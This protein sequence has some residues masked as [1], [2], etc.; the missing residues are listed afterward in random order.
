[1]VGPVIC[2]DV[3]DDWACIQSHY[4]NLGAKAHAVYGRDEAPQRIAMRKK[5]W[6]TE[7]IEH[8][9]AFAVYENAGLQAATLA[10]ARGAV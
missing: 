6:Y 10:R 2:N 9:S 3:A 8:M 7:D 4:R 1:M 5:G